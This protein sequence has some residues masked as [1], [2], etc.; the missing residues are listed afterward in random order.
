MTTGMGRS[1]TRNSE[2]VFKIEATKSVNSSSTQIAES[3]GG[4]A[5]YAWIGLFNCE[6]LIY[7]PKARW[8]TS[9]MQAK[10]VTDR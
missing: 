2:R 1:A 3:S 9:Y 5:Q 7:E 4:Q 10:M 8:L 6:F